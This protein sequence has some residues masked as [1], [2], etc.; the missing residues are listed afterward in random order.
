MY[1]YAHTSFPWRGTGD[2]ALQLQHVTTSYNSRIQSVTAFMALIH[3]DSLSCQ[4]INAAS[5]SV[6]ETPMKPSLVRCKS[7]CAVVG[8]NKRVRSVLRPT[9][10]LPNST[11]QGIASLSTM[12]RLPVKESSPTRTLYCE[13]H[14]VCTSRHQTRLSC[15][16]VAC[17]QTG[18]GA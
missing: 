12:D 9:L 8:Q 5:I 11:S 4:G 1:V 2:Q 3:T 7:C 6:D 15:S 13:L 17:Q 10:P 18:M 16:A 14:H